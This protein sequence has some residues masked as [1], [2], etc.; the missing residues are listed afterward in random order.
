MMANSFVHP[1]AVLIGDV[2]VEENC[3]I[4]PHAVMRGD[5][6]RLTLGSGSNLQDNCCIHSFPHAET[7][8]EE[9]GH[10]GH[11]AIL[12][13]CH[14]QKNA[15][16]GMNSVVMDGATI[17]QNSIV[18]A[19]SLVVSNAQMPANH[20]IVG[21]PATAL[22]ELRPE[23]RSWKSAGTEAYQHLATTYLESMNEVTADTA[24]TQDRPTLQ[25]GDYVTKS[26]YQTES[27]NKANHS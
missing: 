17:G 7:I 11:G 2:I 16:I 21:T 3:F 6:G 12:H 8:V 18:G 5:L 20:M 4:G 27:S 22:R 13:G 26:T 9:N 19:N 25:P 1:L 24:I 23:E 15:L 10:V 14:L